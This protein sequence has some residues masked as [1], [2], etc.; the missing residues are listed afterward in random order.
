MIFPIQTVCIFLGVTLAHLVLIGALVTSERERPLSLP[1]FEIPLISDIPQDE[2]VEI[3][4]EI[5]APVEETA[6]VRP[7]QATVPASVP[8]AVREETVAV[9]N[10]PPASLDAQAEM[11]ARM[12]EIRDLRPAPRS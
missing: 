4:P 10:A 9:R 3:A 5:S 8:D 12:R 7:F 1:A 6:E 2:S 11:P